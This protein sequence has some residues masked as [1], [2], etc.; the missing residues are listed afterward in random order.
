MKVGFIYPD[1]GTYAS[2]MS[3][4]RGAVEA[5]MAQQNESGGVA[6]RQVEVEW[7]D[8]ASD[9]GVNLSASRDLVE[10]ESAFALLQITLVSAGSAQYLDD[11]GVPVVGPATDVTWTQHR[12]MFS[13]SYGYGDGNTVTTFGEY[14]KQ[15]GGTKAFLVDDGAGTG[16]LGD[17]LEL[18]MQ[19]QG[20]TVVGQEPFSASVGS[21][22]RLADRIAASGA[23]VLLGGILGPSFAPVVQ[24]VN[25]ARLPLKAILGISGYDSGLLRE[26]GTGLAGMSVYLPY[27][28]FESNVP[29]IE[30]FRAALL[31][32][33]PQL[34]ETDTEAAIQAYISA[35]LMVRGLEAAGPC[36]TRGSFV[37][38]LRAVSD[39]DAGGLLPGTVDM[40][41]DFGVISPCY[42]FVKVDPAGQQFVPQRVA[43]TDNPSWCGERL[44]RQSASE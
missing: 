13:H 19:S 10:N 36:P 23:D 25:A 35:D 15:A 2:L 44:I 40:E 30:K 42:F 28:P 32:H 16:S 18:S 21:A 12:N 37:A 1:T 41:K 6:G 39:Y 9:P 43:G 22:S 20:I 7:R 34:A 17:A 24:A 4:A 38:G 27:L 11:S 3:P 5:R 26:F 33:T 31:N 8:D 14:V 29:A